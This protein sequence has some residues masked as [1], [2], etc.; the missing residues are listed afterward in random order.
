MTDKITNPEVRVT[1]FVDAAFGAGQVSDFP[2]DPI[3]GVSDLEIR[4]FHFTEIEAFTFL[5][6][7]LAHEIGE[8]ALADKLQIVGLLWEHLVASTNDQ[9]IPGSPLKIK[10]AVLQAKI[11]AVE[12]LTE[13]LVSQINQLS[14]DRAKAAFNQ[15]NQDAQE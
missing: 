8:E 12:Q 5:G 10:D 7:L 13:D 14:K 1:R 4:I 9:M 15:S 2:D 6:L 11:D 3:D